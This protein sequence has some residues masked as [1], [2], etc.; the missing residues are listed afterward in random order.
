MRDSDTPIRVVGVIPAHLSSI[1]LPRKILLEI[2]GVPMIEHVR[3]RALMCEALDGVYVA[4]CDQEIA[5]TVDASGGEVIMTAD[6]HM[7]GTSRVAEA[8]ESVDCTHV[9]L[10]QGDEPLLLPSHVE[11]VVDAIKADPSWDAW[12]ATGPVTTQAELDRHS[13]VKCAVGESGRV[14]FCFRRSASHLQAA[15]QTEYTRKILGVI[16]FGKSFV[17]RLVAYPQSLM[18]RNESIEQLRILE[19]GYTLKS[20]PV[21]HSLPSINEPGEVD[22]VLEA[23]QSDSEQKSLLDRVLAGA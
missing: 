3:R 6:T 17:Q 13:F 4:T 5:E 9:I 20:V 1:R 18:E 23:I 14:L 7:N 16:A 19:H 11:E 21:S 10:L 12:N 2:H 15:E 22:A 8:V